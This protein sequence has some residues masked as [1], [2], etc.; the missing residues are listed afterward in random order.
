MRIHLNARAQRFGG[1]AVSCANG[2]R[3]LPNQPQSHCKVCTGSIKG[4]KVEEQRIREGKQLHFQTARITTQG[5]RVA[6]F[7]N[8]E[9]THLWK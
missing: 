4:K 5:G 2:S 6:S 7:G 3:R 9:R 8:L 1:Y